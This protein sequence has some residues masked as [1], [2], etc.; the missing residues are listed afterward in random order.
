[1]D[2]QSNAHDMLKA[3]FSL[4]RK[5]LEALP[6]EAYEHR[7]GG[8]TRTIPDIVYEVNLVNDHVGMVMRGE[9]PFDWPEGAWIFAP[10]SFR[11]KSAILEAF[12]QSAERTLQTVSAMTSAD[13]EGQV[14]TEHGPTSRFERCQFMS[15]HMWYHSGQLNFMQSLLGDDQMHWG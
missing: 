4:F 15:Q 8:T 2:L 5:D 1:M 11:G 14:E 7:F 6:E 12:N 10:A 3:S 13:L 9:E